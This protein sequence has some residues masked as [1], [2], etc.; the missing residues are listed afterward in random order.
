MSFQRGVN[1]LSWA[2]SKVL[3]V[4]KPFLWCHGRAEIAVAELGSGA[5]EPRSGIVVRDNVERV[6]CSYLEPTELT[7]LEVP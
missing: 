5:S 6:R 1:L 4:P 3:L 2:M 7:S